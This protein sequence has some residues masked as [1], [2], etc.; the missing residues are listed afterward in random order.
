MAG[1]LA[2]AQ[3]AAQTIPDGY[4][5]VQ[6]L[7]TVAP[8]MGGT[9]KTRNRSQQLLYQAEA[10]ATA[11]T[12][13]SELA[14]A[15]TLVA[16]A[17]TAT[18]DLHRARDL[19]QRADTERAESIERDS[20]W[21]RFW[22]I[23]RLTL[24]TDLVRALVKVGDA[25]KARQLVQWMRTAIAQDASAYAPSE[26]AY[27]SPAYPPPPSAE[28]KE[29]SAME[30]VVAA[31]IEIG[32]LDEA[33]QVAHQIEALVRG[34]ISRPEEIRARQNLAVALVRV[35]NI[36][37]ARDIVTTIDYRARDDSLI[38]VGE[39]LT[40]MGELR[41]AEDIVS[42]VSNLEL[43]TRKLIEFAE[44]RIERKEFGQAR[45]LSDQALTAV[46]SISSGPSHDI[47]L[48]RVAETLAQIGDYR[49]ANHIVGN[50]SDGSALDSFR[51]KLAEIWARN[52]EVE[53]AESILEHLEFG[54]GLLMRTRLPAVIDAMVRAGFPNMAIR[55]AG[56]G[57]TWSSESI[58]ALIKA[59]AETGDLDR[60]A[61][62]ARSITSHSE[63]VTALTTLMEASFLAKE[64]SHYRYF[65]E[66]AESSARATTERSLLSYAEALARTANQQA[67]MMIMSEAESIA[68][69]LHNQRTK[70]SV[71]CGLVKALLEVN[72]DDR[73]AEIALSINDPVRQLEAATLIIEKSD[74]QY[75]QQLLASILVVADPIPYLDLVA[76]V[77]PRAILEAVRYLPIERAPRSPIDVDR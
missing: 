26:D 58:A 11:I 50:I 66:L 10:A 21:R 19:I 18:G 1:D 25:G 53:K 43:R 65:A 38:L 2:W 3:K 16:E 6:A 48:G 77:E 73:A 22:F 46:S 71:Q 35:G 63:K 20:D 4:E 33:R 61:T 9:R 13:P 62:V 24:S 74:L 32:D 23:E 60:A 72:A 75:A 55:W 76:K 12:Y 36:N 34:E 8:A 29:A 30:R 52:G 56:I 59:L 5:K 41:Q 51:L 70:A 47:L 69:S 57:K 15:L 17:F 54:P 67:A 45:Y 31:L 64:T 68:R 27:D 42:S 7:T 14:A 44:K 28:S 37:L 49:R 39:V 40:E